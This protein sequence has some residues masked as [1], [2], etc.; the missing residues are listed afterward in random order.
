VTSTEII[1]PAPL[2]ELK[3]IMGAEFIG[4]LIDTYCQETPQLID[5]LKHA[6]A[7]GNAPAFQRAAHSIKSASASLGA[8]GFSALARELEMVGR[9]GN[10]ESAAPAVERLAIDYER[11]QSSLLALRGEG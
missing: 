1:D 11:V 8:M 3:E 7:Q 2:N 10:L 4:E 5:A 9:S 6:L